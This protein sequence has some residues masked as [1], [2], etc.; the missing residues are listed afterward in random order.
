MPSSIGQRRPQSSHCRAPGDSW[1]SVHPQ[2]G[3]R[4]RPLAADIPSARSTVQWTK[5]LGVSC[6]QAPEIKRPMLLRLPWQDFRQWSG[7]VHHVPRRR[8]RRM[9]RRDAGV[10]Q[11]DARMGTGVLR[12]PA[13][14]RCV[15]AMYKTPSDIGM[16]LFA[17]LF[18][19]AGYLWFIV[20][21][22]L[23]GL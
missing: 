6:H 5:T 3:Q 7:S 18:I 15:V 12:V 22:A 17:L 16:L 20:M 23:F 11:R 8:R 21:A 10:Q 13:R 14:D 2:A 4:K 9:A 1:R 19:A